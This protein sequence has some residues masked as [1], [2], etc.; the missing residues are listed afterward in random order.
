[1]K[2]SRWGIAFGFAAAFALGTRAARAQGDQSDVISAH[3]DAL[4]RATTAGALVAPMPS[5]PPNSAPP[6]IPAAAVAAPPVAVP[7]VAGPAAVSA[8][9]IAPSNVA[10]GATSVVLVSGRTAAPETGLGMNRGILIAAGVII[11]IAMFLW[12]RRKKD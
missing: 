4:S 9:P 11:S 5:V 2:S 8:P 6:V 10:Q 7:P 12:D 3:G 1:M